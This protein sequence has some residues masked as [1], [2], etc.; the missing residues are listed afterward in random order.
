[1]NVWISQLS[2]RI[3]FQCHKLVLTTQGLLQLY[4]ELSLLN[5]KGRQL[6]IS[7]HLIYRIVYFFHKIYGYNETVASTVKLFYSDDR[8]DCWS[9]YSCQRLFHFYFLWWVCFIMEAMW[10]PIREDKCKYTL[11]DH[12]IPN[13][14][15]ASIFRHQWHTDLRFGH[16]FY[17]FSLT[18]FG[19]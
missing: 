8:T 5:V 10:C 17:R 9:I 12:S 11:Y 4:H 15:H 14:V 18:V 2:K 6:H 7:M 3:C 19:L 16:P 13:C 1:M